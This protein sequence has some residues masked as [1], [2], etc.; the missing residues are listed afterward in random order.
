MTEKQ[1]DMREFVGTRLSNDGKYILYA[2]ANFSGQ[3]L[4]NKTELEVVTE[5]VISLDGDPSAIQ[6]IKEDGNIHYG[7]PV[8]HNLNTRKI[9]LFLSKMKPIISKDGPEGVVMNMAENPDFI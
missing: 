1:N 6:T 3:D 4:P 8:D 5:A 9:G 2:L 7:I